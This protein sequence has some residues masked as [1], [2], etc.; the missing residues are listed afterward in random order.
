MSPELTGFA[1]GLLLGAAKVMAISTVVFGVAW[2]RARLRIKALEA[3]LSESGGRVFRSGF[4]DNIAAAMIGGAI[5]HTVYRARVHITF[6]VA[7]AA[8]ANAGGAGSV[9]GYDQTMMWIAG[10]PGT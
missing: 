7:V 8:A 10:V 5:A 3:E 6:V 2:W 4:L 9:R 1:L